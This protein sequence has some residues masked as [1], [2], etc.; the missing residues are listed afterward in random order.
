MVSAQ[1]IVLLLSV[2]VGS[3]ILG[4]CTAR[5]ELLEGVCSHWRAVLLCIVCKSFLLPFLA[6]ALSTVWRLDHDVSVGMIILASVPSSPI[7]NLW[8]WLSCAHIGLGAFLTFASNLCSLLSVQLILKFYLGAV[9]NETFAL[10]SLS[11]LVYTCAYSIPIVLTSYLCYLFLPADKEVHWK[12]KVLALCLL[13]TFSCLAFV[14]VGNSPLGMTVDPMVVFYRRK[15]QDYFAV[16]S[17]LVAN[18]FVGFGAGRFFGFHPTVC[19]TLSIEVAM[20]NDWLALHIVRGTRAPILYIFPV[21]FYSALQASCGPLVMGIFKHMYTKEKINEYISEH[22]LHDSFRGPGHFDSD[23]AEQVSL[24]SRHNQA[25][26]RILG[27][28]NK[29]RYGKPIWHLP[30]KVKNALKKNKS[31]SVEGTESSEEALID[32]DTN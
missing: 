2:S 25:V 7:S 4:A 32:Q 10:D 6:W 1:E 24:Q 5:K 3:L 22:I 20:Q 12:W 15:P 23:A 19:R 28:E 13:V 21:I 14:F 8:Q 11:I 30:T 31:A 27:V 29:R 26:S 18:Y 17:F 9:A 16:L